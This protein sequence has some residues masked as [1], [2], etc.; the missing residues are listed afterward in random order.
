[1]TI[2]SKHAETVASQRKNRLDSQSIESAKIDQ[3]RITNP[4]TA[5]EEVYAALAGGKS[6]ESF[7]N[8]S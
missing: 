6:S 1:V 2:Q 5:S 3:T 7:L 4:E 8:H